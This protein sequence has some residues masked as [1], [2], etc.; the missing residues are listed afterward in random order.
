M[1][2]AANRFLGS[3]QVARSEGIKRDARVVVCKSPAGLAC[4][5]SSAQ[6][7]GRLAFHD[8]DNNAPRGPDEAIVQAHASRARLSA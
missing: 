7:Q 5:S 1:I 8:R 6:A 3:L 4:T 2:A